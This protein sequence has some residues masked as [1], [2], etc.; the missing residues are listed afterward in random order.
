M[1][2]LLL[3]VTGQVGWELAR[4]LSVMGELITTGRGGRGDLQLDASDLRQLQ[5]TLDSTAPDVVVNATAYTA[6]DRAETELH[7]HVMGEPDAREGV[8]AFLERREPDWTMTVNDDWPAAW[9]GP[10]DVL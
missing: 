5:A 4:T 9:P 8:N 7:L 1:R 3:G 6:V 2:I 10:E